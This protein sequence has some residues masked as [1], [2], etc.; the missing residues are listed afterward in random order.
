MRIRLRA[1]RYH[2]GVFLLERTDFHTTSTALRLETVQGHIA[3]LHD[4][5][6]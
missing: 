5:F 1:R 4:Y 2:N 3:T 6:L